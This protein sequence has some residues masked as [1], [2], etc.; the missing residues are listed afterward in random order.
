MPQ[1][2]EI[3]AFACNW[4]GYAAADQAGS[5]KISYPSNVKIV[6]VMC[7]GMVEPYVILRAF[8]RGL[9]GVILMGCHEG[10]CHYVSGNESAKEIVK[11]LQ[12][13][14]QTLGLGRNRLR[15]EASS[16]GEG[17]LFAQIIT[18][19]TDELKKMAPNPLKGRISGNFSYGGP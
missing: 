11:R 13:I 10:E 4:C 3:V 5:T 16:A 15:I 1:E 7:L 8:E 17:Q 6:R 18:Q 12:N 19:F 9:D 14:I 2:P